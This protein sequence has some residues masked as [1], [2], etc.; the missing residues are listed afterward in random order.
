MN[1]RVLRAIEE[2]KERIIILTRKV[3]TLTTKLEG[4][5]DGNRD[6]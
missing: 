4:E 5:D 3:E 2:L 1:E 6:T